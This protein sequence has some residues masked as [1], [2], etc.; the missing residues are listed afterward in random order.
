MYKVALNYYDLLNISQYLYN[1]NIF[2][3]YQANIV[4]MH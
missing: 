2:I 3:I 4:D 1:Y